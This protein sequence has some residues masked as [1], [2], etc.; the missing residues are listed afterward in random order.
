MKFS[1]IISAA[2]FS[3]AASAGVASIRESQMEPLMGH[4]TTK[5]AL[6]IQVRSGGCTYK[7]QFKIQKD[8]MDGYTM[9]TFQRT[10]ED[11][12]RAYLPYGEII[13]F[14]FEEVGLEPGSKF[15]VG[16]SDSI[17]GV[18]RM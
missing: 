6:N 12:C 7:K 4:F 10:E 1:Q 8:L 13:T 9:V 15:K 16:N 14:S 2:I 18:S 17:I 5:G 3:L 11:P